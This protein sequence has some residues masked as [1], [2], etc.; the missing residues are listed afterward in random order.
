MAITKPHVRPAPDAEEAFI[1]KAPDGKPPRWQRGNKT[2]ITLSIAP[3]LL[4]RIDEAAQRKYVSRAALVAMWLN[5]R[6]E[7]EAASS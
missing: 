3:E 2:Q 4:Q 1:A 5:D 7:Q 6:L